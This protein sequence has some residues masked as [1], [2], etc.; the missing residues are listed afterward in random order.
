MFTLFLREQYPWMFFFIVLLISM[1]LLLYLDTGFSGVSIVYFNIVSFSMVSLFLIWR[2]IKETRQLKHY[3]G[4]IPEINKLLSSESISFTPYQQK[5]AE[6]F[7]TIIESKE[8]QLNNSKIQLQEESENLLAWV[9]EM[10][11]PLT[12]MKLMIEQIDDFKLNSKL[13]KEWLRIHLLLD[14]QLH[15]T[16]LGTIEQDNRMERF[17]LRMVVYKEIRE[18]QPWCLE[19]GIGFDIEEL[20]EEV[21]TDKKWLGFIVRQL[22]SNAIKYSYE[23]CDIKIYYEHDEHGHLLLHFK[24]YGIGIKE[25]DLPR[26]FN[27]SYTGTVG[28]GS[29]HSTGMGLY[30]AKGAA[31]K[32]GIQ[33]LV[34][35]NVDQGTRFTLSFPLQNEY[36][37]IIGR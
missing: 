17:P 3:L 27:K 16:R 21:I 6:A 2:Y 13:E 11:T 9:H 22:L 20:T 30:L 1:N 34:Q 18:Y 33:I 23:N 7:H 25:E 28:R 36:Q 10:K 32:L 12:A 35:S 26:I 31:D 15:N 37:K 4:N 5:Y 19:K 29:K 8:L 14:Q 24:D